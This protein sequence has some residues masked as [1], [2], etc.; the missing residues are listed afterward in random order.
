MSSYK[1][2]D[3]MQNDR[4]KSVLIKVEALQQE[5]GVTLQQYQEAI[6]NFI[7]TLQT[8]PKTEPDRL[9][10][11]Q[12]RTWWGVKGLEEGTVSTQKECEDMCLNSSKCSGA[13]FNPV[14]RYCWTRSGD[15]F[16][17][18]GR[19]SDYALITEEKAAISIMKYLN[20]RLLD[21]NQKI[22][23]E[24]QNINPEIELQYNDKNAKQQQLTA[25][26]NT[27]IEQKMALDN[28]LQEYYS[29]EEDK[30]NQT[31]FVNKENFLYRFWL[32]ITCLIL[33]LTI[34]Q[35]FSSEF[36]PIYIIIWLII[37]IVLISLTY[38]LSSTSGLVMWSVFLLAIFLIKTGNLSTP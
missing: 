12:G 10:A 38:I 22:T 31:I 14:K 4:I 23:N 9:T 25:S 8:E 21:L 7:T 24:L 28:E 1:S 32:L 37:I 3:E 29:I 11:L 35:F 17:T 20:I 27:L 5:Y 18:A 33:L 16:I 13:T 19:A 30:N 34:H 6:N 26:Y 36:P 15:S 2:I